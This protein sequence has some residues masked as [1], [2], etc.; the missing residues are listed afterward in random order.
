[1][2]I[3]LIVAV[4]LNVSP[5]D[6]REMHFQFVEE[7]SLNNCMARAQPYMARWAADHPQWTIVRW[8]CAHGEASEQQI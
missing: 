7:R 6:C 8:K 2:W 4:C 1:M 3:E 5:T